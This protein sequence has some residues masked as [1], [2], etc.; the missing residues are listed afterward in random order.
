MARKYSINAQDTNTAGTTMLGLTSATTVRPMI[1]QV[2]IGSPATPSDTSA[3]YYL[4]RYTAAGTSTAFTPVAIDPADPAALSSSGYNHSVE[5][6]YTSN[7]ILLRIA[8]YQR[9]PFTWNAWDNESRLKL[10]AT[11]NNGVGVLAN[12]VGGSAT[13][14]D[15]TIFYEE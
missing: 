9:G 2:I 1:Y 5:P 11:A 15:F 14:E 6:T 13:T 10:P 8:K 12:A 3:E 4:Q 7:A